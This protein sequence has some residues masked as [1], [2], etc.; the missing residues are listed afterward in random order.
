MFRLHTSADGFDVSADGGN[1]P[2]QEGEIPD[3]KCILLLPRF[4]RSISIGLECRVSVI[5]HIA[6]PDRKI[7]LRQEQG[8]SG[9]EG[10]VFLGQQ[11]F[12]EFGAGVQ[13]ELLKPLLL[14]VEIDV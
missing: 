9:K 14:F 7:I 2:G 5:I 4:R 13:S 6:T 1:P 8:A 12:T 10:R 11:I 3:H